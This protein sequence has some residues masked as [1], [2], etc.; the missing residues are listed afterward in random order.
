MKKNVNGVDA[1]IRIILGVVLV[2]LMFTIEG[3]IRWI[4]LLGVIF[5]VT[6]F[7]RFCPIYRIFGISTCK[8]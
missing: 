7:V 6:A 5:I 3:P 2:V 8:K 1:V 4:G